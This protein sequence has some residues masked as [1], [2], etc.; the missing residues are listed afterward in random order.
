MI[1]K[2]EYQRQALDALEQAIMFPEE[3]QFIDMVFDLGPEEVAEDCPVK[4]WSCP[5]CGARAI[6]IVNEDFEPKECLR[7]CGE[8]D[9]AKA[10]MV[11]QDDSV[12]WRNS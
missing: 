10:G 3:G 9:I 1:V 8:L 5:K 11:V 6:G 4:L 12:V 2:V 7:G